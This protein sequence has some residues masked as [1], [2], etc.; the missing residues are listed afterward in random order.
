[1]REMTARLRFTT[2]CL[3]HVKLKE[4]DKL[5]GRFVLMRNGRG[6]VL[7]LSTWWQANLRVAAKLAGRH[8]NA[9][10][11][12]HWD[13]AIDGEPYSSLRGCAR[14]PVW[15]QRYCGSKRYSLHEAFYPGQVVGVHCVLPADVP[16]DDFV[17]LMTTVGRYRGI[18]PFQP[19]E[20]G[21]FDVIDL[22]PRQSVSQCATADVLL[23]ASQLSD[24]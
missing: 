6:K 3:G 13:V 1:M 18:S 22:V 8:H 10:R 7:F 4:P 12:I 23:K 17:Q 2:H 14:E 15:F 5:A 9:V 20:W 19:T 16:D 24:S 11:H 21:F